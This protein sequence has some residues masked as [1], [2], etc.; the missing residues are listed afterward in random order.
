MISWKVDFSVLKVA[1]HYADFNPFRSH[2]LN[3]KLQLSLIP[4]AMISFMQFR[5]KNYFDSIQPARELLMDQNLLIL[6]FN[7]LNSTMHMSQIIKLFHVLEKN[8]LIADIFGSIVYHNK[9]K[10]KAYKEL[11]WSIKK[12]FL[13]N[14][15]MTSAM[16]IIISKDSKSF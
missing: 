12:I 13:L 5:A 15:F 16:I 8:V 1:T 10:Y 7:L 3:Q 11:F 14:M 2:F 4:L 6:N 9:R